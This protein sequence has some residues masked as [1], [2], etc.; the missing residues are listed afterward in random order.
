MRTLGAARFSGPGEAA[1]SP[2]SKLNFEEA[3]AVKQLRRSVSEV[4]GARERKDTCF[5]EVEEVVEDEM[6]S[7]EGAERRQEYLESRRE[8]SP[9]SQGGEVSSLKC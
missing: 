7:L 8:I 2:S 4:G 9:G 3:K 1:W 5:Q 6:L